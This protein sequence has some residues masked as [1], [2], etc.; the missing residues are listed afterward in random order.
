M[1]SSQNKNIVWEIYNA[2]ATVFTLPAIA[3]LLGETNFKSLS[4]KLNYYVRTGKLLQLR[5]GIYAKPNYNPE[6]L[7]CMLYT[8][9]YLSLEYVLQKTG[10][11]FQYDSRLTSVSYLSRSVEADNN[12]IAYRKIKNE[13][14]VN[15]NGI[16]RNGNINIAI[17]ERA[18]LD[19]LY[20]N[21]AYHFDN[22]HSLNEKIIRE[23]LLVYNS[24]ILIKR[25]NKILQNDGH[26]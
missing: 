17:P 5:K 19:I 23:L 15:M 6:E 11:I 25:V 9:S 20:L 16:Q 1:Y 12:L 8:P 14:L 21:V 10:V 4:Q 26:Q 24:K 13:I 2:P 7:A 18:F 22:I 3:L